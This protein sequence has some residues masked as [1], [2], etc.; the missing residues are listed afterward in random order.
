MTVELED[1]AGAALVRRG[2]G[3]TGAEVWVPPEEMPLKGCRAA[4]FSS[5]VTR[6]LQ[7][8][9]RNQ[10]RMLRDE[11]ELLRAPT[12]LPISELKAAPLLA[13]FKPPMP[14]G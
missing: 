3:G 12:L 7:E 6:A 14:G 5:S 11:A 1:G 2:G 8:S 4:C 9:E 10:L 13:V